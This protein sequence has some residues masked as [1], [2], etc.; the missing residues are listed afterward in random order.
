MSEDKRIL[1]V[2]DDKRVRS[3]LRSLLD[4][5]GYNVELATDGNQG[6][7]KII[8][9]RPVVVISDLRMPGLDGL[10]L[11][12]Q[13]RKLSPNSYFIVLT[14]YG[15]IRD[16]VE[17]TKLGAFNFLTKPV[18]PERLQIELRNC[19]DRNESERQLEIAH[20]K[21]RDLGV[22]GTLE[23]RSKKMQE[24]MPI[25][26]MV[27]PSAASVLICGESGTGKELAARTIHELSLSRNNPFVAVNCAAIP[28]SLIESELFGHERGAFTG[29]IQQRLGCFELAQGGTLLLDEIGDMPAIAQA[30]LLRVLEDGKVRRLGGVSEIHVSARVLAATNKVPE[31]AV[32]NGQ[33][34]ND[35]FFRLN[36]V[37]ISMPPLRERMEDLETLANAL[38]QDLNRKHGRTIQT[39]DAEAA[40]LMLRYSWPGNIRELRNTLERAVV[41]CSGNVI[42]SRDLPPFLRGEMKR[43]EQDQL[44]IVPG[45]SVAEVERRHIL[46][47]L[48]STNYNKT[49][50]AAI[51]GITVKTLHNK[52]K[53]YA[54]NDNPQLISG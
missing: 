25:I 10:E 5:W 2:E 43:P 9:S 52:L 18:D 29:A 22:L 13:A 47:T 35:L 28:E 26:S 31:E 33:L 51:L 49:K 30:K 24:V 21:L 11:L 53:Q 48:A 27:A 50:A 40:E 15:T 54:R 7:D 8:S 32:K 23:G 39:I 16:A 46:E 38:L 34:R 1:V 45:L 14:G 4:T 3:A 41:T 42:T 44:R 17:A 20:R 36:V 37:R 6:W 12:K 19:F